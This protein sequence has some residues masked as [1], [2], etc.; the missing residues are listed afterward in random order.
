MRYLALACDYDGTLAKHGSL[1]ED[2]IAALERLRTTGRKVVLVTGR[3]LR[4]LLHIM[5]R[6]ELF[7]RIVAE[8]GAVLYRPIEREERVLAEAP[9]LWFIE[10]LRENGVVPLSVGRA[11]L[12][13]YAT[14]DHSVLDVIRQSG[15]DVRIVYNQDALMVLPAGVDKGS[16]L[17]AALREI[18]LSPHNVVGIGNAE[19]DSAFL[20]LCE[21]SAAPADAIVLLRECVDIVTTGENER[22]VIEIINGLID[23]DLFGLQS[24]R[25]AVRVGG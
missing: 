10:K 24:V 20:T 18:Q 16:G 4:E 11:I 6:H 8:N 21:C 9:P 3:D 14:Q 17:C 23:D 12:A 5:P 25:G 1:S 19:N 22:G 2:T 15:L 13:T 7:D